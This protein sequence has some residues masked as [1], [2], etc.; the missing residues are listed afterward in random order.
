MRA[1]ELEIAA[2]DNGALDNHGK[3]IV[4][5]GSGGGD[6]DVSAVGVDLHNSGLFK[7]T[8][9]ALLDFNGQRPQYRLRHHPCERLRWNRLQ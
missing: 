9:G 1:Y 7:V 2:N 5:G 3:I 4:S 6:D 8:D